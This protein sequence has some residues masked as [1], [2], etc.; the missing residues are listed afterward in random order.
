MKHVLVIGRK[1]AIT[2]RIISKLLDHSFRVSTFSEMVGNTNFRES[3]NL[4]IHTHDIYEMD[5]FQM[6]LKD[7]DIIV[8]AAL[9]RHLDCF[10]KRDLFRLNVENTSHLINMALIAGVTKIVFVGSD[11]VFKS[12]SQNQEL[13]EKSPLENNSESDLVKSIYHAEQEIW[14]AQAE[15]MDVTIL[16]CGHIIDNK[17]SPCGPGSIMHSNVA[18]LLS[19]IKTQQAFIT[20][21]DLAKAI[22]HCMND[23]LD[24]K[25]I[26]LYSFLSRFS[27]LINDMRKSRNSSYSGSGLFSVIQAFRKHLSFLFSESSIFDRDQ[28]AFLKKNRNYDSAL[29]RSSFQMDFQTKE[30]FIVSLQDKPDKSQT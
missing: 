20:L 4:Y 10:Q 18:S 28:I 13:N 15:G 12:R 30:D 24:N 23:S 25:R 6:L 17:P 27:D 29:A 21:D 19:K 11:C 1:G 14:R 3:A 2:D 22:I 7:T 8:H 9:L 26:L 5:D 16:N